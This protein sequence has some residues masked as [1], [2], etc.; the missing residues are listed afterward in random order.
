MNTFVVLTLLMIGKN[1]VKLRDKMIDYMVII[2]KNV[3][4]AE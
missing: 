1:Y 2:I 3:Y 4:I